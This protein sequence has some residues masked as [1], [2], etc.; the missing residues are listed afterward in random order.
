MRYLLDTNICIYIIK[1]SP[2][3]VYDRLKKLHVGDVGVSAITYCE[4]QFGVARSS[5][6]EE[7]QLA[8]AEF[9]GPLEVLDFPSEAAVV[10]GAIRAHVQRAG[11]PIGNYDLLIAAHALHL[12]LTVVTNN[13]KEFDRVPGLKVE[14]WT[15]VDRGR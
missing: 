8:L 10:F 7:N 13:T 11:L 9:L 5:R 1:R 2:P 3:V 15:E 6:P 4:L 12:G 14:N